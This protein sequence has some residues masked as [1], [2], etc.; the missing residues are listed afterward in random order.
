ML[1]S[2]LISLLDGLAPLSLA[3]PADNCGLLVGASDARVERVLVA[4]EAT[5]EVLDEAETLGCDTLLTHHPVLYTPVRSLVDARPRERL[6]RRLMQRSMNLLAWH[7][8]L[9]AA[10]SGLAALCAEALGLRD[11]VPLERAATGW[12]KLVG[13]IPPD[14][15]QEVATAVFAAGAGRIG[16][17]RDCAYS[18]EG[19]GWFTAEP[20]AHPTI[21]VVAVPERTPEVRWETVVPRTRLAEVVSAYLRAHPY[22]EP[23]FDIY[24]VEDVVPRAGL[25]RVGDLPEPQ[26]L[27]ALAGEVAR[28]FGLSPC[29]FAGRGEAVVRRVAV[30][31]G[32]GRSLLE[33]A[34]AQ[35]EVFIT[36]DLGYH[37]AE[38]AA[39][40]GLSLIMAPHGDLEWWAFQ[41]WMERE[42]P[43]LEAAG[44]TVHLSESWCSPWRRGAGGGGRVAPWS[45]VVRVDGGSR[46]NPGPSAIGVVLEDGEGHILQTVGRVI[47]RATNNVAEYQA[48]V[49]GLRMAREAGAQKV[50]VVADSE[51]LVKQMRGE[52]LVRNEGL[53]PLH[54]E[55]TSLARTFRSFSIRHVPRQENA[56][57]D[58]LVNKALDEASPATL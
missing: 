13:F 38:R 31:P 17:Y 1:V 29:P 57:A 48:L 22:E 39:E 50:E 32:S 14:A 56:V 20:G 27:Y 37:D 4:L 54:D 3:G 10:P 30:L 24:P 12:Y 36:G 5:S 53:K 15:L 26:T 45:V 34:A 11:V 46:G 16:D 41:R 23:A 44:A 19:T 33:V 58:A 51:L 9:D 8:N 55:A 21:G 49:T 52:Y 35:A 43:R 28:A 2:D 40:K 47:G 42:R 6:L 25:G 7:T 18:L